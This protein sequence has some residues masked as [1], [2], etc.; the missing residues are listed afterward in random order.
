MALTMRNTIVTPTMT[1]LAATKSAYL[2][3]QDGDN[4]MILILS[5]ETATTATIGAGDGPQRGPA[6]TVSVPVGTSL[7]RL[8][9][10]R[11]KLTGG[12]NRGKILLTAVGALKYGTVALV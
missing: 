10:G 12:A 2:P 8:D 3:W 5:A 7:L 4:H 11:F 1:A 6:M 9:S